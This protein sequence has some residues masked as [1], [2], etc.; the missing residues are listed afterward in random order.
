M[1][2]Y[3]TRDTNDLTVQ[4]DLSLR[5]P[6]RVLTNALVSPVIPGIDLCDGQAGVEAVTLELLLSLVAVAADDHHV[7][8]HPEGDRLD[9]MT[10]ISLGHCL[11]FLAEIWLDILV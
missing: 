8:E 1:T 3:V 2:C 5:L 9:R 7:L 10:F 4:S 11:A 6:Q